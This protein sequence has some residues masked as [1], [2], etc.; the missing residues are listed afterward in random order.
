MYEAL[1]LVPEVTTWGFSAGAATNG[2]M[3]NIQ[4]M[5]RR[6]NVIG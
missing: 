2:Y 5:E 4:L 6:T 1:H 3:S